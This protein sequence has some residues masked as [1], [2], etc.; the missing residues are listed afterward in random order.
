M[1]FSFDYLKNVIDLK[2][3]GIVTL[4]IE[5]KAVFRDVISA[6][7]SGALEESGIV[8]SENYQPIDYKKHV[9]FVDDLFNP[10]FSSVFL[11]KLYADAAQCCHDELL[12]ETLKFKS[13]YEI[14]ISN[15]M[16]KFDYD[17]TCNYDFD[18]AAFLKFRGLCPDLDGE[19]LLENLL[20]YILLTSKYSTV[21]CFVILNLHLFFTK[22]ELEKFFEELKL[23]HINLL[24]IEGFLPEDYPKNPKIYILD[25]DL[26]EISE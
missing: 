12:E 11:K 18:L 10:E 21:K 25:E 2:E 26:C 9:C 16:N 24:V 8:F 6:F 22:E 3:N 5:N 7:K 14:L 4:S 1:I 17:L 13:A 15:L 19:T 23:N 20:E